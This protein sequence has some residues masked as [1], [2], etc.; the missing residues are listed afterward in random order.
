MLRGDLGEHTEG[1]QRM[2]A[3][4]SDDLGT[5]LAKLQD[6]RR[7]PTDARLVLTRHAA[8]DLVGAFLW[9]CCQLSALP[10]HN[11]Y[12]GSN[13]KRRVQRHCSRPAATISRLAPRHRTRTWTCASTLPYYSI[14]DTECQ[15][16]GRLD[17]HDLEI[18]HSHDPRTLWISHCTSTRV[19]VPRQ[20]TSPLAIHTLGSR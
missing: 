5:S 7:L 4:R 20:T 17:F 15:V 9:L 13:H 19:I 14:Q 16:D 10:I 1:V 8:D 6:L 11:D 12:A 2:A 18:D 3:V